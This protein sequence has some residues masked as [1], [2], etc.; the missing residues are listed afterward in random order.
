MARP[1]KE[2]PLLKGENAANFIKEVESGS[3]NK[4]HTLT[5]I[6]IKENFN[7]L[8]SIAKF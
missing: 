6:R 3:I 2:T 1:I 4:L 8:N 5:V 7:K